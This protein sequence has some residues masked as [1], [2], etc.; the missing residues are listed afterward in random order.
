MGN[1]VYQV[2]DKFLEATITM[3]ETLKLPQVWRPCF[4]MYLSLALS[5]N[6]QEG[7][8]YWYTDTS[9]GLSFS[10]VIY[11]FIYLIYCYSISHLVYQV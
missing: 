7:M 3:W 4:Y 1:L 5:L 2:F 11:I 9:K 10:E 6:I 8:F